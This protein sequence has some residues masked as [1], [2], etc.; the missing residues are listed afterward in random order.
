[1]EPVKGKTLGVAA[2]TLAA[3]AAMKTILRKAEHAVDLETE[4]LMSV[5]ADQIGLRGYGGRVGYGQGLSRQLALLA[6]A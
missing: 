6:A 1:M 5:G 4:A 3:N 2:T